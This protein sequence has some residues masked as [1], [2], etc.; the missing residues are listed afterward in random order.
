MLF[1]N[2]RQRQS[3]LVAVVKMD[4]P[5]VYSACALAICSGVSLASRR[6]H[7]SLTSPRYA[8]P[9][10]RS[11]RRQRRRKLYRR[12]RRL[13]PSCDKASAAAV[14]CSSLVRSRIR[15][16]AAPKCVKTPRR[17]YRPDVLCPAPDG[18]SPIPSWLCSHVTYGLRDSLSSCYFQ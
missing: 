1:S 11:A 17:A 6:S 9:P 2:Q 3:T 10:A 18:R 7:C 12:S 15:F 14:L 13:T 16:D 8:R 5:C 4:F